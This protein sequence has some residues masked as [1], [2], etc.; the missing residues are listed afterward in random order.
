MPTYGR[1][2]TVA[3][4]LTNGDHGYGKPATA[5]PAGPATATPGVLSYYEIAPQIASGTLVRVWD[6][7]TLT[8]YAYSST[9]GE[10]VTYDDSQSLA[11][12]TAFVNAM[13]L[14]GA[15]VWAIDDDDFGSGFPLIH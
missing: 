11:Y 7:A 13:G 15:M 10:W 2:F 9:S 12:K 1:S 6:D 14:G 3:G 5:A 4:G 8:P